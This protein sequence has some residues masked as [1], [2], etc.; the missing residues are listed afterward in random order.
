MLHALPWH[1]LRLCVNMAAHKTV[2]PPSAQGVLDERIAEAPVALWWT[3][4]TGKKSTLVVL[5]HR[6]AG[7]V[8][9]VS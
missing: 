2:E 4:G 8:C 7:V 9:S 1:T 5:S 6:N 3:G